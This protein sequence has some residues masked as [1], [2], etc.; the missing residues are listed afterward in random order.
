MEIKEL[1]KKQ[2]LIV[3]GKSAVIYEGKHISFF[4]LKED[5]FRLANYFLNLGINNL[6]KIA[7]YLPNSYEAVISFL[8]TFSIGA[9]LV[10]LD[11]VFTQEEV[12]NLINHSEAKLLIT[13]AKKRID[14]E[15][16]RKQ[17]KGLKEIIVVGIKDEEFIY[18][19]EIFE[20]SSSREPSVN[21]NDDKLAT[22]L[23]TS[24][25]WG[26]PK[27]VMLTY[28][29]LDCPVKVIEYFLKTS[30]KDIFIC[31]GIPLSHLGG[32]DYIFLTIWHGATM[33]LMQRFSPLEFLKNIE[34]YK[35]TIFWIVPSMYTAILSLKEYEKFDLSSLKYAVVFGAP[36]SPYLLKKFHR[37]CPNA[38]LLNGWGMTETSAPNCVLPSGSGKIESIGKFVPW[39]EARIVDENGNTLREN[40]VGE[41]W[42][43]GEGVMSGYYKQP[44]L[45]KEILTEDGWLKTGDIAKFDE[46]GLFYI[47]GRKKDMIK[48]GGEAVFST[49]IEEKI[50]TH[51]KVKEVA[52]IGVFDKLRGEVP[53]AFVVVKEGEKLSEKELR[54]FLKEK[55]APFKIPHYFEFVDE[56]PK[57]RTGKVYKKILKE[58]GCFQYQKRETQQV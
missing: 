53:K 49:E 51:P 17:C 8:A 40:E 13:Q 30:T 37:L 2:S 33:V 28:K 27:G 47:V 55:L 26:D 57:T 50:Y 35:V 3:P 32:L 4:Q 23:Y 15:K 20:K 9:V 11:F 12:I 24:G 18:W 16:I 45:T 54:V 34:K 1:L 44:E 22:I 52:V 25:S 58:K 7:V 42:V 41:L 14:L 21:F 48:V 29:H 46:K 5:S 38:Y 43:R 31:P 19:D 10:P 56:L 39:M 36:S 6:D